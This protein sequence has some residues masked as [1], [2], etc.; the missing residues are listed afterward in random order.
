MVEKQ[1]FS[2][3]GKQDVLFKPIDLGRTRDDRRGLAHGSAGTKG[4]K[5]KATC[6]EEDGEEHTEMVMT[7]GGQPLPSDEEIAE[8]KRQNIIDAKWY[9]RLRR[10]FNRIKSRICGWF[11]IG[12]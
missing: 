7:F 11:G 1:E 12:G 9:N 5:F 10:W 2:G 8:M 3:F 6:I 4:G